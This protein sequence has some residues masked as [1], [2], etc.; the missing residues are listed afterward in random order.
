MK[1][2]RDGTRTTTQSSKFQSS[3][4]PVDIIANCLI[5]PR[6]ANKLYLKLASGTMA[7]LQEQA[8]H[9]TDQG[10]IVKQEA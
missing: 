5:T 3:T 9:N 4:A 8:G 2:P 7:A 1:R 10:D 6:L